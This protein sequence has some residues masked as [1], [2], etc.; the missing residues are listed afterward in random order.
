LRLLNLI[1]RIDRIVGVNQ[2]DGVI[3]DVSESK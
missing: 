3:I 1:Q 2:Y